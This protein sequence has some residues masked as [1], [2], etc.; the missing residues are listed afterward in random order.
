MFRFSLKALFAQV[1]IAGMVCYSLARP[2]LSVAVVVMTATALS[3]FY[4]IV[5]ASKKRHPFAIVLVCLCCCYLGVADGGAFPDAER[6]LPTEWLLSHGTTY[7]TVFTNG[8]TRSDSLAQWAWRVCKE[9]K[10]HQDWDVIH[11]PVKNR[12]RD[13]D[14]ASSVGAASRSSTT[15]NLPT[16]TVIPVTTTRTAAKRDAP[17][18]RTFFI[19]GHCWWAGLVVVLTLMILTQKP[20]DGTSGTNHC[21]AGGQGGCVS[22]PL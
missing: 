10:A 13:V 15:V 17:Q 14:P 6:L 18:N 2:S 11:S 8:R 22:R 1:G 3:L 16:F 9:E 20:S 7:H 4:V 21:A 19:V 5:L 12:R